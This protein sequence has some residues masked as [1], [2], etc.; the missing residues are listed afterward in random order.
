M[1]FND[2][3]YR[4]KWVK[5][6]VAKIIEIRLMLIELCFV[7]VQNHDI[8]STKQE[9]ETMFN[10]SIDRKVHWIELIQIF[11]ALQLNAQRSNFNYFYIVEFFSLNSII[12]VKKVSCHKWWL[13]IQQQ[14]QQLHEHW[15]SKNK[16]FDSL[17]YFLFELFNFW[18]NNL[19]DWSC[20]AKRRTIFERQI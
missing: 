19:I 16:R 8:T 9:C 20:F 5:F 14:M 1:C 6:N 11:K 17:T 13:I 15:C 4:M 18:S 2:V 7:V 12:D 10:I 3:S